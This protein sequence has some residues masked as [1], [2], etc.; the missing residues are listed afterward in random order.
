VLFRALIGSVLLIA[1][2]FLT[3]Q[4]VSLHHKKCP[5]LFLILSGA[6]MGASWMFLYEAYRQIGVSVASLLNYCGPIILMA[7]SPFLFR[8]KLTWP[9]VTGFITV[10]CGVLLVNTQL[11]P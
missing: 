7:L 3:K 5:F 4:T 10:L 11:L 6:A 8:E 2:F 9:K 1:M